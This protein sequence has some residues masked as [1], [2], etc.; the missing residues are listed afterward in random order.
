MITYLLDT[1]VLVEFNRPS[2][3]Y[4]SEYESN[5]S[6]EICATLLAQKFKNKAI[7][8]VPSFCIA[9]VKNTY[10]KWH[11][12]ENKF[13][14]S[15]QF[16]TCV[17]TFCNQISNRKIFYSY[18]LNRY[19]N[20]NCDDIVEIEH[21]EQTEYTITGLP[22]GSDYETVE[23]KLFKRNPRDRVGKYYLSSFDILIIA[24]GIELK[25]THG[26]EVHLVTNDKRLSLIASK[27]PDL[28]PKPYLWS[29][30]TVDML[31]RLI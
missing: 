9:E 16:A 22:P 12:R 25:R 19:H 11:Y 3:T 29:S 14:C 23:E 27:K 21:T 30:L 6:K 4:D 1:S 10:A 24:M 8:Y 20:I 18:D 2:I 17:R 31:N 13:S 15:G 28:F 26:R 5:H 7:L